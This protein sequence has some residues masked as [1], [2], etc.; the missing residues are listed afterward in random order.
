MQEDLE[1]MKIL[2]LKAK[3]V[4]IFLTHCAKTR[5]SDAFQHTPLERSWQD[6]QNQ[7]SHCAKTSGNFENSGIESKFIFIFFD[8]FCNN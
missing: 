2:E 6:F 7:N 1:T 3:V 4:F 5:H 8:P